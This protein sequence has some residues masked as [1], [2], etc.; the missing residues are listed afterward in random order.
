MAFFLEHKMRLVISLLFLIFSV[1]CLATPVK[2]LNIQVLQSSK[3]NMRLVFKLNSPVTHKVFTLRSPNRLVIDFTNTQLNYKIKSINHVF[4]KNIRSAIHNS[5]DL[6]VVLDLTMRV[7]SKSFLIKSQTFQG[8]NLVIDLNKWGT[9]S[10]HI[11]RNIITT[12]YY[13]VPK[14][15]REF[16]VA[17]D[18]GHGGKD[19]G[20]IGWNGTQEKKVVLAI[21]KELARLVAKEDGMRPVMIRNGDY[22]VKLHKR[23]ELARQSQADL[24]VSIHADAYPDDHEVQ[25]SSVFMLSQKGAT[26]EAARWLA[27]KE[28]AADLIGG[29]NLNNKDNLLA[30]VLLDLSQAGTLKNSANLGETVLKHLSKVGKVHS[31]SLHRA[32]FVVLRSPDIPSILV[33]TAFLS[34]PSE[35]QKINNP[36][37]R[38]RIATAIM[39]GIREYFANHASID[40][41]SFLTASIK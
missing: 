21:A 18:A 23:L 19:P 11:S 34:N 37:Y 33:E 17:I 13:Q 29:I 30:E 2:L 38:R 32:N 4:I 27:E 6:R 1:S 41:R 8:Y 12:E 40:K 3:Y 14:P 7:R 36:Y 39:L 28:N 16:V 31:N 35:E 15:K 20:A 9:K 10:R 24:F 22:F 25:G 26:S 5:N